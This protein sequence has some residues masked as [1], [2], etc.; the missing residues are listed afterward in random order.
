MVEKGYNVITLSKSIFFT[1]FSLIISDKRLTWTETVLRLILRTLWSICYR[2]QKLEMV[3]KIY[4]DSITPSSHDVFICE[5]ASTS[6]F[7][8]E[9]RVDLRRSKTLIS[10][11]REILVHLESLI[12]LTRRLTLIIPDRI[13]EG[14]IRR[15][16]YKVRNTFEW[17]VFSSSILFSTV[18]KACWKTW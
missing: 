18:T 5:N 10:K 7:Y 1:F 3:S 14:K 17:E 16:W 4:K 13:G 8:V 12:L 2:P 15:T 6:A 9:C 11:G